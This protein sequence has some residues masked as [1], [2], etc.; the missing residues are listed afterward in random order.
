M[1]VIV[2][3]HF[4]VLNISRHYR[5]T[6]VCF[7]ANKFQIFGSGATI[8]TQEYV[9]ALVSPKIYLIGVW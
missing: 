7:L 9:L 5:L 3:K 4:G 8:L 2:F 6:L 1:F